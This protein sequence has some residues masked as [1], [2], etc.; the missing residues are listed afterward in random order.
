MIL[1]WDSYCQFFTRQSEIEVLELVYEFDFLSYISVS[2]IIF[3]KIFDFS[4]WSMCTLA[5]ECL[6]ITQFMLPEILDRNREY[7]CEAYLHTHI[8]EQAL[9]KLRGK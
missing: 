2:Q 3:I 8:M 9:N 1:L 6:H 5:H 7:E 4:D